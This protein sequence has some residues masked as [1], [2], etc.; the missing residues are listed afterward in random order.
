MASKRFAIV[1]LVV[2]ASLFGC[3]GKES[4]D[5]YEVGPKAS[6]MKELAGTTQAAP[7]DDPSG[8]QLSKP[9]APAAS[10]REGR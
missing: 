3:S 4:N 9:K 8:G 7:A 5:G 10:G 1:V 2:V 6:E